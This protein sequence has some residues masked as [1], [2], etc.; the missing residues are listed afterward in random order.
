MCVLQNRKARAGGDKFDDT[1]EA[2]KRAGETERERLTA[3]WEWEED[4]EE[5]E[6]EYMYACICGNLSS[7]DGTE[8]VCC[9]TCDAWCHAVCD[10]RYSSASGASTL[11]QFPEAYTC[12]VCVNKAYALRAG[13]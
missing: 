7:N 9:D 12:M 5:E 13:K 10:T 2:A 4:E 3:L 8:L 1:F 11:P 6:G